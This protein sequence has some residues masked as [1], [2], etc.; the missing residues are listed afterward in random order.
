ME[1]DTP[2]I[3]WIE[4]H[5]EGCVEDGYGDERTW[6]PH[7][8]CPVHGQNSDAFWQEFNRIFPPEVAS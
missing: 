7:H 6:T 8:D 4:E 2:R 5:C 1:L 3:Q